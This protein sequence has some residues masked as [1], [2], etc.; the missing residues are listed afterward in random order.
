MLGDPDRFIKATIVQDP[1]FFSL[2]SISESTIL[3]TSPASSLAGT[4]CTRLLTPWRRMCC[5]WCRGLMPFLD[6][7]ANAATA[8]GPSRAAAIW[9]RRQP[10]TRE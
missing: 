10:M 7:L 1:S 2:T 8:P 9:S 3:L 6:G 5:I 4:N